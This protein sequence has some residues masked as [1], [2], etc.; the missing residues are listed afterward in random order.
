MYT[1]PQF[2][3]DDPAEIRRF[4]L[5]HSFATLVAVEGGRIEATHVPL[6]WRE[7]SCFGGTEPRAQGYLIGH[8]ARQNPI[9]KLLAGEQPCLAIFT[10]PHAYVSPNYYVNA[11][12]VPTWLYT[13]IHARGRATVSQDA[14]HLWN[15][16][17]LLTA[18]YEAVFPRPW[19]P[20]RLSAERM[21]LLL[22]NIVAVEIAVSEVEAKYK[23]DQPRK[24]EDREGVIVALSRS[25]DSGAG[26]IAEMM[27][28]LPPDR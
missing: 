17:D 3:V 9:W 22:G 11:E 16:L 6:L 19:T 25:A 26:A 4:M 24:P 13:A 1:P 14:A 27:R 7:T 2:R 18:H 8:V 20:S 10:G 28:G 15:V 12:L 5:A 21:E 23:L